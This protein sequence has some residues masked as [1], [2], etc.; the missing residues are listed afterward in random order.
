[1]SMLGRALKGE[2]ATVAV[3]EALL[4]LSQNFTE[5]GSNL[6]GGCMYKMCLPCKVGLVYDE[7]EE[8]VKWKRGG[9]GTRRKGSGKSKRGM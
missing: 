7:R 8:Y 5:V 3:T 2:V 9:K 6:N 4:M 1:M